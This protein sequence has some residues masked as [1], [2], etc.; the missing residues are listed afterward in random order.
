MIQIHIMTTIVVRNSDELE[1]G[2]G[3]DGQWTKL[4]QLPVFIKNVLLEHCHTHSS[5]YFLRDTW[6]YFSPWECSGKPKGKKPGPL[7]L[8]EHPLQ[9]WR[10]AGD[11]CFWKSLPLILTGA[12]GLLN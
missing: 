9:R 1:Q 8:L 3:N 10:M 12:L 4:S 11:S 7:S 6:H 2:L 5:T